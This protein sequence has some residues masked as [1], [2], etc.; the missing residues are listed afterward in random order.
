MLHYKHPSTGV[1]C[2]HLFTTFCRLSEARTKSRLQKKLS[3]L[4]T[5]ETDGVCSNMENINTSGFQFLGDLSS[6]FLSLLHYTS[7]SLPIASTNDSTYSKLGSF[8]NIPSIVDGVL[9]VTSS[10]M[11][12]SQNQSQ[13]MVSEHSSSDSYKDALSYPE[14]NASSARSS[15]GS[16]NNIGGGG[17][18]FCHSVSV[19]ST[20]TVN[21]P[22][23]ALG[24]DVKEIMKSSQ[25]SLLKLNDRFSYL[26]HIIYSFF[27][28][29]P[30]VVTGKQTSAKSVSSVVYG[31][32]NMLPN[33]P[34]KPKRVCAKLS[35]KLTLKHLGVYGIIGILK[36]KDRNPVPIS[37]R[38]YISVMDLDK[39]SLEAPFYQGKTLMRIFDPSRSFSEGSFRKFIKQSWAELIAESYVKF[40]N[41]YTHQLASHPIALSCDQEIVKY[42]VDTL[43][44][45]IVHAYPDVDLEDVTTVH[46]IRLNN[47]KC[48]KIPNQF[49]KK[50]T[51]GKVK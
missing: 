47:K 21:I 7:I 35:G 24:D 25:I 44:M 30:V 3:E 42:F 28:G 31:L 6:S 17:T 4:I 5:S 19:V 12:E 45:Q 27:I 36:H 1:F 15:I 49:L 10:L 26:P 39:D 29:R 40:T 38:P 37:L 20:E 50:K 22:T 23:S 9:P 13:S 43:R 51:G 32:A 46:S 34:V 8:V 16:S 11:V 48:Q 33:N 2:K 41:Q 18:T 14:S